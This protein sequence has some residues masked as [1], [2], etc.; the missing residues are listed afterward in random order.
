MVVTCVKSFHYTLVNGGTMKFCRTCWNNIFFTILYALY[1]L[2]HQLAICVLSPKRVVLTLETEKLPRDTI[3]KPSKNYVSAT[4]RRVHL[5]PISLSLLLEYMFAGFISDDKNYKK[6]KLSLIF[7][8]LL[9][10]FFLLCRGT[11]RQLSRHCPRV[12]NSS[13]AIVYFSRIFQS[14]K[15]TLYRVSI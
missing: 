9:M 14:E 13:L 15:L 1:F 11:K 5:L 4:D 8:S 12:S 7:F 2:R 6:M 3:V 10:T